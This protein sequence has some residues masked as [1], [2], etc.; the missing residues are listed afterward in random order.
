MKILTRA[1]IAAT[2][3]V[4]RQLAETVLNSACPELDFMLI[5][6]HFYRFKS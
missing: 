1:H 2:L 4:K 3:G 5:W 6:E